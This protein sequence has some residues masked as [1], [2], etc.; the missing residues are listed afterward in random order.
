MSKQQAL[1]EFFLLSAYFNA[2]RSKC[3][4]RQV[5]AVL[6][7]YDVRISDG[8]N[9]TPRGIKNCN[10]GGCPRC[11]DKIIPS[12]QGLDKCICIH[13]ES[14]AILNAHTS[15]KG[16]TLYVTTSPCL[17]CAKEIVQVGIIRVV[18]NEMYS[19][20]KEIEEF[21]KQGNIPCEQFLIDQLKKEE[22]LGLLT[23][24]NTK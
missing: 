17:Y 13:A 9:G 18:Y 15:V 10:D 2:T 7:L 16:T 23:K 3:M 20:V 14:N 21:L 8:Y 12:G 24:P 1:D 19:N 22:I 5:G 6:A 11:N 4:R